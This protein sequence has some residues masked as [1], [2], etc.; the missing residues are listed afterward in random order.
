MTNIPFMKV[1]VVLRLLETKNLQG[2]NEILMSVNTSYCISRDTKTQTRP[3]YKRLIFVSPISV[4]CKY[5][6]QYL[7]C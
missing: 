7:L 5:Q 3:A 1:Y 6:T 2:R 4:N